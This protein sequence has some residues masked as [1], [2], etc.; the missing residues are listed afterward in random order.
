MHT[1]N[2]GGKG[3]PSL[4]VIKRG[5]V[6]EF[7]IS[8]RNIFSAQKFSNWMCVSESAQ[9]FALFNLLM[10]HIEC[11]LL[12]TNCSRQICVSISFCTAK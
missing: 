6:Q 9:I 7:V 4:S 1:G 2:G 12:L 8:I 3:A 10:I 11:E 5:R